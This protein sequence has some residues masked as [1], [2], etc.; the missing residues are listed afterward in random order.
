M[1]KELAKFLDG[2]HTFAGGRYGMAR[3]LMQRNLAFLGPYSLGEVCHIVQLAIQHRRR[4]FFRVSML[5]QILLKRS[6]LYPAFLKP[7]NHVCLSLRSL[8][9]LTLVQLPAKRSDVPCTEYTQ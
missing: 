9:S 4:G 5:W 7:K 3:E 1:W 2:E 8:G 6:R